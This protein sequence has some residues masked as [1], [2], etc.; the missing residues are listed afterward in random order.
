VTDLSIAEYRALAEFRYQ[1]RRFL[2]F[3]AEAA[4]A[5]GLEPQQH[6]LLLALKG[7]PESARPTIGE[8]AERLQIQHHSAVELVNRL[9]S[10]GAIRREQ[11]GADHREVLI[12]LTRG[13]EALLRRLSLAHHGELETSGPLL[14]KA[15]TAAIRR[16]RRAA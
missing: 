14:A 3:S 13:G 11:A 12:R 2:Q 8:L 1:I 10:H 15:L 5:H 6:Q 16:G 7:L 9:A 4:R